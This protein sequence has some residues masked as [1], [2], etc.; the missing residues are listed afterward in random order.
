[1]LIWS[2]TLAALW[3]TRNLLDSRP[4]RA[5]RALR[6]GLDMVEAFGVDAARLKIVVFVYALGQPLP[7]L[8][9]R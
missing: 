6:G 2:L 8:W 7:V 1:L 5:V 9:S 4:G 3:A